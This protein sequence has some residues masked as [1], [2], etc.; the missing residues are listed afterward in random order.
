GELFLS[1]NDEFR[2]FDDN[3]GSLVVRIEGQGAPAARP[4]RPPELLGRW[5]GQPQGK[6]KGS[7][8]DLRADGACFSGGQQG[9]WVAVSTHEAVLRWPNGAVERFIAS[10]NQASVTG[11]NKRTYAFLRGAAAAAP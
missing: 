4:I 8:R 11:H 5:Q 2:E 10:G 1:M 7:D 9:T 6:K 3:S